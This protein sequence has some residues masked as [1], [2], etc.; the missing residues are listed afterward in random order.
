MKL[1]DLTRK[2]RSS[3]V[4][5]DKTVANKEFT[6]AD[7]DAAIAEF[8]TARA[9]PSSSV[10]PMDAQNQEDDEER[11]EPADQSKPPL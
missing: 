6:S 7:V 2:H 11:L 3:R 5:A 4:F 9:I 8:C 1:F 10:K